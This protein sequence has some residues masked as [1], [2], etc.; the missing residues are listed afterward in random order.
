M[1]FMSLRHPW[2]LASGEELGRKERRNT[3]Y[4]STANGCRVF[5]TWTN[6][7]GRRQA[8]KTSRSSW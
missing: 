6:L 3:Y 4:R 2:S 5:T 1:S 7:R 8:E